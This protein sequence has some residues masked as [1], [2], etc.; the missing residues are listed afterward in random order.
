VG[1]ITD[2]GEE[3]KFKF[4]QLRIGHEITVGTGIARQ[5]IVLFGYICTHQTTVPV[6]A[7]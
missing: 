6:S 1:S 4:I 7:C 2:F 5:K 3:F